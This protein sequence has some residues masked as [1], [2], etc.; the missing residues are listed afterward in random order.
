MS[1]LFHLVVI[2]DGIWRPLWEVEAVPVVLVV[3]G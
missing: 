1:V 2:F 3:I